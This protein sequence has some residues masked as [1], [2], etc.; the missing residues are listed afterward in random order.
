VFVF[1]ETVKQ[2][3]RLSDFDAAARS[4]VC[5]RGDR[6]RPRVL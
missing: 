5:H 2:M 6:A 1:S 4:R 3:Q